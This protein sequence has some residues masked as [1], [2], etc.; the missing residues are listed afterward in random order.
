V[1]EVLKLLKKRYV[2]MP[3]RD[4]MTST[5]SSHL[6]S[7]L[8]SQ[9]EQQSQ[10]QGDY[11]K[12]HQYVHKYQGETNLSPRFLSGAKHE[13]MTPVRV[14]S[15]V[16]LFPS[17][18]ERLHMKEEGDDDD[19]MFE[20]Q[21]Y[22][23]GGD[24]DYYYEH[25]TQD[26]GDVDE[27]W[28]KYGSGDGDGSGL[29]EPMNDLTVSGAGRQQ[30][31]VDMEAL[32][33]EMRMEQ[34]RALKRLGGGSSSSGAISG[35]TDER[36]SH[37]L[38]LRSAYDSYA[39]DGEP[40]FT[41]STLEHAACVDYILYSAEK[42]EAC[43]LLSLPEL[44]DLTNDDT[45]DLEMCRDDSAAMMPPAGWNANFNARE[46]EENPMAYSGT[47]VGAIKQNENKTHR[48]LPNTDYPSSH[49]ALF[50]EFRYR[51]QGLEADWSEPKS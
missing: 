5:S 20:D 46:A 50:V 17:P 26:R 21:G 31:E 41:T 28:M 4:A 51:N 25:S 32:E 3:K 13:T 43:T 23:E 29:E 30:G 39:W 42:L 7:H 22:G 6:P 40:P 34:K 15:Q 14:V 24:G 38:M 44:H 12:N 36:Q 9:Q 18:T 27:E 47:W 8:Q 2:K 35:A 11:F 49:L 16:S 19:Q 37:R 33:H 1:Q 45:R 10:S 48:Y